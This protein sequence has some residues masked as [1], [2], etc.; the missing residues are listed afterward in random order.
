MC[1]GFGAGFGL[2]GGVGGGVR[3]GEEVGD[4]PNFGK[5]LALLGN[6][7]LSVLTKNRMNIYKTIIQ[8][9]FIKAFP[10]KLSHRGFIRN[11]A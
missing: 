11:Y 1:T 5:Y 6:F 3:S 4:S 9:T 2:G 7:P 8:R 10:G